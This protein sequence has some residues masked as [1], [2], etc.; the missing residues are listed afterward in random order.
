MESWATI[1]ASS[2]TEALTRVIVCGPRDIRGFYRP[3]VG[4]ERH[5]VDIA[6]SVQWWEVEET[7]LVPIIA[8]LALFAGIRKND[9]F[10]TY[11]E[12]QAVDELVKA[13]GMFYEQARREVRSWLATLDSPQHDSIGLYADDV[14]MLTR[15]E[16]SE[17]NDLDAPKS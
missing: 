6:G 4:T 2:P 14:A 12:R 11:A 16:S 13:T 10:K 9:V 5:G 3:R 15:T 8:R 7:R 1:M 17:C